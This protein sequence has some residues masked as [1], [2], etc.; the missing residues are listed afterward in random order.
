MSEGNWIAGT[1]G[2]RDIPYQLSELLEDYSDRVLFIFE[3]E[4]DVDWAM[5]GG[6]LAT[7]NVGGAGNWKRELNQ[8]LPAKEICI[9]PDNDAA[10]LG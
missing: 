2:V 6:L 8:Y 10:G 7:C 1:K 3:G 5:S 4:K 9:F